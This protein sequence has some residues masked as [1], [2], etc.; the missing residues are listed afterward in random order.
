MSG[1]VHG[2]PFPFRAS[3]SPASNLLVGMGIDAE[4]IKKI[5]KL[6]VTIRFRNI[7]ANGTEFD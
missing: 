1:R 2:T 6:G 5:L 7:A 3:L 4:Q